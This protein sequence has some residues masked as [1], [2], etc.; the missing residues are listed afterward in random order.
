YDIF[1]VDPETGDVVYSVYKELDFGT[2]LLDGPHSQTNFAQCFRRAAELNTTD[3]FILV[4]YKQYGP[5][6]EAPASF[7]A[8]PIYR[9][10]TRVGIA[11]FQ[12]PIDYVNQVM[13]VRTGMGESGETYLVGPDHL[14]RCDSYRDPENRSIITSFKNPETGRVETVGVVNALK[15]EQGTITTSNYAGK[16]V[17]CSYTPIEL[18]GN[19]WALLSEIE[20]EEAFA[21]IGQIRNTANSAT[22]SLVSWMLGL[23]AV[24][25]TGVILIGWNFSKRIVTPVLSIAKQANRI[26]NG[27]LREK[28]DYHSSDELG[29]LAS[30]FNDM[31]ESI[32]TMSNETSQMVSE[33]RDGKLDARADSSRLQG[34][35]R[36]LIEKTNDLVKAFG[37][38]VSEIR[39]C[40]QQVASGNL[41]ARMSG[42][43]SGD[44]NSLAH[45]INAALNQIDNTISDVSLTT[46]HVAKASNDVHRSSQNIAEGSTEQASSLEE[47]ASSLE[48]MTSMTKHASENATQAKLLAKE[49]REA[50]D[51]GKTAMTRM[52]E[53]IEKIKSSSDEQAK[54]VRTI[55]EIAFQTNLLAL[56][57]AVEAARAGEAGKGFA[58]VAEEVRSL[59]QR[60]AEAAR[61]TASMID[62]SVESSTQG[63]SIS[64]EVAASLDQILNSA[65][66]T[67][68]L[69]AEIA[70]AS[71]E[72]S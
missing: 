8:S 70:A 54:I 3:S 50:A 19:R 52:S 64:K 51:S 12:M 2:S 38:P 25:G 48:E 35:Y 42:S 45:S 16:E 9:G 55:D 30:S 10:D 24:V 22:S 46:G 69:V 5:S 34:C 27:D 49:T 36:E 37:E 31:K 14:M 71:K 29:E 68:D 40:M 28:L 15:G 62:S 67:D 43:Y 57:A 20:K 65:Q 53:A 33:A 60:S 41:T 39:D 11:M 59:A 18:L 32:Q 72:Q 21:S 26:A 1:L 58:V 63:V 56:N 7:I 6:Y 47:I 17:L 61:T 23:T 66:K 44:F 4:D 13:G